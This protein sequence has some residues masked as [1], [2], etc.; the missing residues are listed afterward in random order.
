MA[1]IHNNKCAAKDDPHDAPQDTWLVTLVNQPDDVMNMYTKSY[2]DWFK[3]P[4][5]SIVPISW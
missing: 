3:D 5:F 1:T 4:T 2:D